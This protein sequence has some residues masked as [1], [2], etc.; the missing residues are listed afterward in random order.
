MVTNIHGGNTYRFPNKDKLLDFSSNINPLGIPLVLK[1]ELLSSI[2]TISCYP[3]AE[4]RD[5]IGNIGSYYNIKNNC[6][7]V[8][9]GA[10]ELIYNSIKA[11][12]S[13]RVLIPSPAFAE[14]KHAALDSG[15]EVFIHILK[16]DKNF[17]PDINSIMTDAVE[18]RCDTIIIC[19]PN[20]PT[21]VLMPKEKI[22]QLASLCYENKINVIIDET[23]IELTKHGNSNSAMEFI[24]KYDNILIIRA[25]TKI[26]A[27]PGLRLG[28]SFSNPETTLALKR[29]QLQWSVNSL[30]SCV[31]NV[32]SKL[33]HYFQET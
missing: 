9:N 25:F 10:V 28:Y 12:N 22:Q 11:L 8:S 16:S 15:A 26:L 4:Y 3:D 20:N 17:I 2:D 14:Y 32:L 13:K 18:N 30:A 7:T 31:G 21:S 19:N 27:I 29:M 6:I 24:E 23:F 5:L 33:D 1:D